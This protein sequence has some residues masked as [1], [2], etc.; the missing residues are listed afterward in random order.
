M[1]E[2]N[3]NT[4]QTRDFFKENSYLVIKNFIGSPMANI[5]YNYCIAKVRR[6]AFMIRNFEQ[7]YRPNWDGKF[8][9]AQIPNSYNLYGDPMMDTILLMSRDTISDYVGIDLAP[10]YTYWRFYEKNDELKRHRD[11]ESCEISATL[12][13]GYNV[14]NVDADKYPDY[15]WP[16]WVQDRNGNEFPVHLKPGDLIIYKGCDLDHWREPYIG[17]NH[18]Q[19][20]FHFNDRNGPY[21][22]ELDG[23]PMIGV[24]TLKSEVYY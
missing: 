23:R 18:A 14:S 10:N 4:Q 6:T 3:N 5:L 21:K 24:P 2:N 22:I 9:D 11:R 15:D 17:L 19:V 16:M 12:C 13:L 1:E 20:F 8:G 7:D